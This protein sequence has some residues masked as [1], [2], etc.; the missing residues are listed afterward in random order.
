MVGG[1]HGRGGN[2]TGWPPPPP[3]PPPLCAPTR[4]EKAPPYA[5]LRPAPRRTACFVCADLAYVGLRLR[6]G[7]TRICDAHVRPG[8]P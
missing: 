5:P 6:L 3:P 1:C 8:P 4:S 7:L 2:A